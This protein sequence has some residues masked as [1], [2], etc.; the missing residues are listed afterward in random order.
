MS[1]FAGPLLVFREMVWSRAFSW[2]PPMERTL[3]SASPA[4]L[5]ESRSTVLSP[6]PD[7]RSHSA[8]WRPYGNLLHQRAEHLHAAGAP[9]Q[10]QLSICWSARMLPF[11]VTLPEA[12]T[13]PA[14][15]WA[16]SAVVAF[17][18]L[19]ALT[20]TSWSSVMPTGSPPWRQLP[21][22]PRAPGHPHRAEGHRQHAA[23]L[24]CCGRRWT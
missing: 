3:S 11:V 10:A 20:V 22:D 19:A 12:A 23:G 1:K 9:G 14:S 2:Q 13:E 4:W 5:L 7:H 21:G 24:L 6:V 8:V 16:K 15:S 17:R 18:V